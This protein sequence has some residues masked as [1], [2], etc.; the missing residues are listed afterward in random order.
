M[1]GTQDFFA[2]SLSG[3]AASWVAR[4]VPLLTRSKSAAPVTSPIVNGV[5]LDEVANGGIVQLGPQL[6]A[7][8]AWKDLG[9]EWQTI[10]RLLR[11][12]RIPSTSRKSARISASTLSPAFRSHRT[13]GLG[14][15]RYYSVISPGNSR[16]SLPVFPAPM[17]TLKRATRCPQFFFPVWL[18]IM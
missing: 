5:I 7:M 1:Q 9:L 13:R 12:H 14:L 18:L 15:A 17:R 3:E 16:P 11:T 6:V 4:I 10:L 2:A 8:E